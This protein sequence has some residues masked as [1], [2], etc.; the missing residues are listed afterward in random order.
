MSR[1]LSQIEAYDQDAEYKSI[2]S[3]IADVR[4]LFQHCCLGKWQKFPT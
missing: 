2:I 4:L 3:E 1:R